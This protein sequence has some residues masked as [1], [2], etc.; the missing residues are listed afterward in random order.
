M[1]LGPSATALGSEKSAVDGDD[2]IGVDDGSVARDGAALPAGVDL[3]DVVE[4]AANGEEEI[5]EAV[6]RHGIDARQ[7]GGIQRC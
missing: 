2:S 1:P 5:V 3:G 7:A 4:R 6:D